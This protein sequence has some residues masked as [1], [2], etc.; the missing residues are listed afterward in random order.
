MEQSISQRQETQQIALK[1]DMTLESQTYAK[2]E[3]SLLTAKLN[4]KRIDIVGN[5]CAKTLTARD[6]KGFGT[7]FDTQNGVIEK[8]ER[9]IF[10]ASNRDFKQ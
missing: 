1:Q 3:H 7:G 4:Y 6:Y 2:T 10:Q 8:N 9:T 5:S